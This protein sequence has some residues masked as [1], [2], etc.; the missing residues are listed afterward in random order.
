M[1][2]PGVIEVVVGG[3]YSGKTEEL[4]RRL[5]RAQ[6]ARQKTQVFKPIIDDRYHA[7]NV[8][9]HDLNSF[10]ARPVRNP[11]EILAL[12][13]EDTRVV[14]IDEAQF[15]DDSVVELCN[16]LAEKGLRVLVAGLDTDWQAQPFGPMPH[17]M[18]I[19]DSVTKHHAVCVVCGAAATRTQRVTMAQNSHAQSAEQI[20]VGSH[21]LYEARCRSHFRP[22]V[23]EAH[24]GL[25]DP[26]LFR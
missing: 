17:L 9:S 7:E 10:T 6:F 12:L 8:M 13:N 20:V 21:G 15:F 16:L 14:G 11:A 18:A 19:A 22:E 26:G 2:L 3:M 5:R 4:I 24:R 23:L 1:P 25:P